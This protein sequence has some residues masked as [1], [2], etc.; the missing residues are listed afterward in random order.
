MAVDLLLPY[1]G[2]LS[3]TSRGT[4]QM[5]VDTPGSPLATQQRV[6]VLCMTA[7]RLF[8]V[9]GVGVGRPDNFFYPDRGG[10]LRAIVGSNPVPADLD[11]MRARIL[12][13][14]ADDDGIAATPPPSV[15]VSSQGPT[16][17]VSVVCYA[18]TGDRI[19][20]TQASGG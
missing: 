8:D 14:L 11:K 19:E 12:A 10:G 13:G 20:V 7:P 5:V 15:T 18:T 4:P 17:V 9:N 6:Q 1:G 16:L 2:D 3:W